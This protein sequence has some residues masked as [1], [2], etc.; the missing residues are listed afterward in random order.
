MSANQ[1]RC[2]S[3][4]EVARLVDWRRDFHRHPELGFGEERTSARVAQ[5]LEA[6][7]YD[8]RRGVGR[9]GV[10]GVRGDGERTLMIRADMDALPIQERNVTDYRS[11]KDG[12]M[13]A[14]GHDGHVAMALLAA[15]R[16]AAEPTGGRLKM[17]FQ[18]AEEG[19][20]GAKAMIEDGVLEDPAPAAAIGIHLWNELPVGQVVVR[21]GPLMASVDEFEIVIQG[22]GGHGAIPQQTVDAILVAAQVVVAAQ[23][24]VSRNVD[25]F[26]PAVVTFGS[27]HAGHVFN[28]IAAEARLI[29][30]VRTL[31]DA[32]WKAM[33]E[34]L[35]RIVSGVCTAF[36]ASYELD[37]RRINRATVNDA[38]FAD[39]VRAVVTDVVGEANVRQDVQTMAGED[40]SEFLDRVPGCFLLLG[41]RNEARGLTSPHHSP[42]F[43][44]D[45][46]C[47]PIGAEIL[48]CV[49]RQFL[50]KTER[51]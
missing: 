4:A 20:G 34:R 37:Y 3:E 29:G 10:V 17:V 11:M 23:S 38:S 27:L 51:D 24:I 42:T 30:T 16:L 19:L 35:E 36:G 12:V 33:P 48:T 28:V 5:V 25:P 14:C 47:L 1:T 46:A 6:A 39:R 8:V 15:E 45:E 31:N 9:T 18:P 40:M 44:F 32:D 2:W 13:H 41:S 21:S 43:D 22:R 49:A 26:Q 50:S 7:G